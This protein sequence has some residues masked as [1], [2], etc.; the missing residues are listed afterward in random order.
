MKWKFKCSN[1]GVQVL[2][3]GCALIPASI[4]LEMYLNS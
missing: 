4:F 1:K 2:S 3:L